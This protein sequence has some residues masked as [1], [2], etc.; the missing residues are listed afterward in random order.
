M[1]SYLQTTIYLIFFSVALFSCDNFEDVPAENNDVYLVSE[2]SVTIHSLPY[3]NTIIAAASV[4]Y[5]ELADIS[6]KFTAPV[7]VYRITYNTTFEGEDVVASGLVCVPNING[8]YPIMSFQNGTNSLASAAPSVSPTSS[9]FTLLSMMA[10]TGF[11]VTIPDY[12]GFGASSN[13]FHPYLDKESTVQA[14][15][16][17]QRAAKE[18]IAKLDGININD[19]L[20]ITGYSQ[21]G[22]STLQ[23]QKAIE[24][25]YSSEFNLKASSGG[26][27][28]YNLV[29]LTDYVLTQTSYPMPFFLA[30]IMNSYANLGMT[31]PIDSVF[32]EPYAS[33]VPG[34]F[35]GTMDGSQINAQLTY[36]VADLF[37]ANFIENWNKPG[38]YESLYSMLQSNS[39]AGYNTQVPTLLLHG[40]ADTFVPPF[41]S[42]N[43]Y[44]EFMS[45]GVSAGLV[46]YVELDGLDH[47]GAIIPAE[48]Q[49]IIWFIQLKDGS[50]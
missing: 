9:L 30:Y 35:D 6:S 40:S 38:I 46:N 39:M 32:N 10:S 33:R 25:N 11:V 15:V 44:T 14:V 2:T 18:L 17:M 23:L 4:Q 19:D 36:V 45:A 8:T 3:I 12:L 24:T 31:T 21:G 1:K 49:A 20:Y 26:S 41:T 43:L 50:I 13:M 28:P 34:L 16:D 7:E 29:A 37:T 42:Q 22:W 5:P 27:G 48:L 47:T